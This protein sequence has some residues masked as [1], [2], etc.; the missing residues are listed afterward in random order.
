[1][2]NKSLIKILIAEGIVASLALVFIVVAMWN[3][4]LGPVLGL[5]TPTPLKAAVLSNPPGVVPD[6]SISITDPTPTPGSPLSQIVSKLIKPTSTS[7]NLCDGPSVMTL[8]LIGS[9]ER[10]EGYLYGLADSIRIVRIDF[11]KPS[12]TMVDIPRDLWV[13]IPGIADHYGVTHGKV[14]QAY[15][16]GNP[17][18]GYYDGPGEGPGLLAR[19]LEQNFGVSVDH[20]LALDI[21]TFVRLI[22][23]MDGIDIYLDSKI[24]LNQNH[25]GGN[26]EYV[27]EPGS[28]HLDGTMTLRLAMNRYPTIFQR[29]KNQ[30]IVLHAI[31]NK[32]LTPA[33]LPKLP[34]LAKQFTGSVQ[35]D[36]SPN[37]ISKL[38]CISQQLTKDNTSMLAFPENMFIGD[39]VY[40]P[41][42][43]VYTYVMDAD[44]NQ[45][46]AYFADFMN[47]TWPIPEGDDTATPQP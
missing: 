44:F 34:Q 37:D 27:L 22:D 23:A 2:N 14:N 5:P 28:H 1:M 11:N 18:M 7:T 30:D 43:K 24:D 45:L 31:Q 46:R 35:T 26:P 3:K 47:G 19:T 12:V 36:L 32:L 38:L 39:H 13:E 25:D 29:A 17:G 15:F 16:F 10:S 9:D 20:Y 6:G 4:P 33:M 42:R 40:D 41:Y 8:L 21:K